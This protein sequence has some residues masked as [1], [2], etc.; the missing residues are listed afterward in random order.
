M[1]VVCVRRGDKYGPEWV[2]MLWRMVHHNVTEPIRFICLSDGENDCET[3]R[4]NWN[5]PGWWSKMEIF[6][7]WNTDL[8]P[9]L[10]IDLDSY[11]MGDITPA[12]TIGNKFKMACFQQKRA[13]LESSV[14]MIPQF[15]GS[16]W[17]TWMEYPDVHMANFKRTGDQ[18]FLAQ[19]NEG[20]VND[21]VKIWSYK[22]DKLSQPPECG[23]V[24]FHGKPK[25]NS[26]KIAKWVKDI[27]NEHAR[28]DARRA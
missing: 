10:Y 16:I 17:R 3:R 21:H 13:Q 2:T 9:C 22:K 28:L 6:S 7:P 14:M 19:F 27:W 11:I 26:P 25:P 18:G 20:Y 4:L 5:W 8:R 24:Q 23:I 12:L 15:T 1:R